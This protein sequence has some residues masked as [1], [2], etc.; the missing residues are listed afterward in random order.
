MVIFQYHIYKYK[1][2]MENIFF[3]G[4]AETSVK[5]SPHQMRLQIQK[6]ALC[7]SYAGQMQILGGG[8]SPNK[9]ACSHHKTSGREHHK[10]LRKEVPKHLHLECTLFK[11]FSSLNIEQWCRLNTL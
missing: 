4:F 7:T 11:I 8:E 9:L 1:S 3:S 5:Q 10:I 2:G 6:Q